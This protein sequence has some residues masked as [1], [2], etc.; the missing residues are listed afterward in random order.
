[1]Q[2]ILPCTP[3]NCPLAT[4]LLVHW[5]EAT[6]TLLCGGS[7]PLRRKASMTNDPTG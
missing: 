5:A 2:N 3:R 7:R 6:V 1:M 4:R